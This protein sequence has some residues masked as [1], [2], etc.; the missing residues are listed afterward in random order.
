MNTTKR[1]SIEGFTPQERKLLKNLDPDAYWEK[2]NPPNQKGWSWKEDTKTHD[3][4]RWSQYTKRY[5]REMLE[6]WPDPTTMLAS[7]FTEEKGELVMHSKRPLNANWKEI[8]HQVHRLKVK[9]VFECGCGPG[10]HLVNIYNMN[11]D[12]VINGC[13]YSQSQLDLGRKYLNLEKYEFAKRLVVKDFTDSAGIDELGKHEFVYTQAV[14][15]HLSYDNAKK[16]LLNM[17]ELST[18]YILLLENPSCHDYKKLVREAL[19]EYKRIFGEQ[20]YNLKAIL[21]KRIK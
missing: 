6:G 14:T 16:F 18:K 21:L 2:Y 17:K 7:K 12:I 5:E 8:Y 11:P 3:D 13:D 19:P 4:H 20:K 15:M 10:E 1:T 9:S